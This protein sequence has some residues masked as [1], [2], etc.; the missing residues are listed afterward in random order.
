MGGVA[1][2]FQRDGREAGREVVWTMLRAAPHQGPDGM[3]VQPLGAVVLGHAKL[4]ITPEDEH[5]AQPL[6][7]PR[8]GCALTAD[9]RLDNRVELASR[10]RLPDVVTTGDAEFILRAYE[11]WGLDAFA[12]LLGDF[13][14]ILWDPRE[15]RLIC[16]RDTSGRRALYY[17]QERDSF[18]AASEIQQ[19][20]QDPDFPVIPNE[21][22]I[23]DFLTPFNLA[24]NSKD[25]PATFYVGVDSVPAGHLLVVD[26]E[27]IQIRKYWEL[28]V[29]NALRYRSKDEYAEHYRELFFEVVRSRLRSAHPIGV[30]LSG[31]LDS[32]SIACVA[33]ELYRHGLAT[34][35][36]FMS[37]SMVFD[38]LE[39][40]EQPLV[41]EI[42][43]K[44]GF[45]THV[46]ESSQLSSWLEPERPGFH[47]TPN[48][49]AAAVGHALYRA[50]SQAGVRVLLSGDV[51]DSCI[52]GA[53]QVYDSLLRRGQVR[54]VVRRLR[55]HRR[56]THEPLRTIVALDLIAPFTPRRLQSTIVSAYARHGLQRDRARLLP[57]WLSVALQAD[58]AAR[59]AAM[60]FAV[61]RGRRFSNPARE[62]EYRLLYPPERTRQ[63]VPWAL[64]LWHPFADRRLHAF[65]LAVPPEVKFDPDLASDEPY[66]AS[67]QLV[68]RGLRGIL[69]ES[70]RTRTVKAHFGS[71]FTSSVERQ[72]PLYQEVFGPGRLSKIAERGYVDPERFWLR[73]QQL[74]DGLVGPDLIYLIQLISLETW[75]RGFSRPRPESV[76]VWAPEA[77]ARTLTVHGA[78]VMSAAR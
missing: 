75:L 78:A 16:A 57:Y 74:R 1:A 4:A 63:P 38:G 7:S 27:H 60:L 61:E 31:G 59:H 50:A 41:E 6:V 48:V 28:A 58:L 17:R 35:H 18:A 72:W 76:T 12:E 39:C 43:T 25:N 26:R 54:E 34:N 44:Y 37:F 51:A 68:R 66:A 10:L 45:A 32:S 24:R 22:R 65:L 21:E 49:G 53:P 3:A 5:E 29:P 11:A 52:V 62:L 73:L 42:G 15:Q 71:T 47:D 36:G 30:L 69:P 77:P 56:V 14:V 13:A 46:V 55:W 8:T 19:L 40:D 64:Q 67:K 20:L 33:Q 70:I 9:V 2:V 23:R